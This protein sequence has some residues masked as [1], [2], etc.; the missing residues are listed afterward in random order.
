MLCLRLPSPLLLSVLF[1]LL[2][3]LFLLLSALFLPAIL[4]TQLG[5]LLPIGL[6]WLVALFLRPLQA[7]EKL[8]LLRL[9]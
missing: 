9:S 5:S 6:Y 1:L 8:K 3:V 4:P 7:S 2:S